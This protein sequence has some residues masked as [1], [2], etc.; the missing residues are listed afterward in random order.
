MHGKLIGVDS[1]LKESEAKY[2]FR[3]P[4]KIPYHGSEPG[5]QWVVPPGETYE[6]IA[7]RRV[8]TLI[9]QGILRGFDKLPDAF[10]NPLCYVQ[11]TLAIHDY[12]HINQDM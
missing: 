9:L 8:I 2:S 5:I 3:L 4:V 7:P 11:F 6:R 12:S 10:L 1:F